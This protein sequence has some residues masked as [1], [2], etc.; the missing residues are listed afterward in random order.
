[1]W[2]IL[3]I[4]VSGKSLLCMILCI[5][6]LYSQNPNNA[7]FCSRCG[8]H[9]LLKDRYRPLYSLGRGGFGITFLATDEHH[10]TKTKCVIKQLCFPETTGANFDKAVELFRQEALRLNELRHPQIPELLAYFE[11]DN[12]LYLIQEFITTISSLRTSI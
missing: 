8:K 1:M 12:E 9:L 2:G 10:P 5:S 6:C 7:R 11:Q 4:G 3:V